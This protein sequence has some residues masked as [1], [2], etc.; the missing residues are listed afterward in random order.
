M[1]FAVTGS[2]GVYKGY[3]EPG[4]ESS[5]SHFFF[6][7]TLPLLLAVLA[8]WLGDRLFKTA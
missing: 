5:I 4:L 7:F 8:V 2:R 3:N 6:F 1:G